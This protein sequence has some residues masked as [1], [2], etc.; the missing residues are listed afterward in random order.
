MPV[1]TN[2]PSAW[3]RAK[4]NQKAES[5]GA[6][7]PPAQSTAHAANHYCLS[8]QTSVRTTTK[9]T[10]LGCH[11]YTELQR[12]THFLFPAKHLLWMFWY[13][14][15]PR[16]E[17]QTP[18][19]LSPPSFHIQTS[20]RDRRTREGKTPSNKLERKEKLHCTGICHFY[21]GTGSLALS[22]TVIL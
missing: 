4:E 1:P 22:N 7:H 13:R 16:W 9:K 14:L 19:G 11:Y 10:T 21:F 17:R 3:Q 6:A 12:W 20:W 18:P 2:A 5:R 15:F 8:K